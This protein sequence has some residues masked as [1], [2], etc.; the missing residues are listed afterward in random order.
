MA[1]N[2]KW[3]V[4]PYRKK[5]DGTVEVLVV[6]TDNDNWVLP[7]GNLIKRIGRKKTALRE[8]FEEAGAVGE[9]VDR[10]GTTYKGK[11]ETLHLYPMQ[12]SKL[13]SKRPEKSRRK[14]KWIKASKAKRLLKRKSMQKA[15]KALTGLMGNI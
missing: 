9:I 15:V 7:K 2:K 14:R 12:V 5:A 4:V 8:A 3:G 1:K 11:E 13:L 10:S 6:T